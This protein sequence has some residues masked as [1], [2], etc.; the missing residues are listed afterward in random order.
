MYLGRVSVI[1]FL[2]HRYGICIPPKKVKRL[3]VNGKSSGDDFTIKEYYYKRVYSAV[4]DKTIEELNT[5]FSDGVQKLL[6]CAAA[7]TPDDNFSLWKAEE[8][9]KLAKIYHADIP[10]DQ[11]LSLEV[12]VGSFVD[13][14]RTHPTLSAPMNGIGQLAIALNK[15]KAHLVFPLIYK[16][17]TLVLTL[18]VSS[19]TTERSFSAMK[20][21]K[22]RLRTKMGDQFMMDLMSIYIERDISNHI[23]VEAI[24]KRFKELGPRRL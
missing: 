23:T 16:L 21:I 11:M 2:L 1:Y 15:S 20:I 19:A 4:L 10:S 24:I 18:P 8:I 7:L 17:I 12:E 22:T 3:G 9:Y 13:Y 5:R 6:V 14:V